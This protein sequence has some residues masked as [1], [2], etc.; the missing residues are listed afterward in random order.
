MRSALAAVLAVLVLPLLAVPAAADPGDIDPGGGFLGRVGID[1]LSGT[2]AP[3]PD[4]R[5]LVPLRCGDG[6]GTVGRIDATGRREQTFAAGGTVPFTIDRLLD[7]PGG[8]LALGFGHVARFTAEGQLDPTFGTAGVVT[9]PG[10]PVGA[11]TSEPPSPRSASAA[12]DGSIYVGSAVVVANVCVRTAALVTKLGPAGAIDT[13]FGNGGSVQVHVSDLDAATSVV[14]Q[15]DGVL[16]GVA[17]RRPVVGS[18]CSYAES[19]DGGLVIRYKADGTPLTTFGFNGVLGFD[20]IHDGRSYLYGTGLAYDAGQDRLVMAHG[21]QVRIATLDGA[22][23]RTVDPGP[24]N[25]TWVGID[26]ASRIVVGGDRL[27]RLDPDGD[28]DLSWGSCGITDLVGGASFALEADGDVQAQV[29]TVIYRLGASAGA[30]APAASQTASAWLVAADGSVHTWGD[31]L[32]CGPAGRLPNRAAPVGIAAAPSGNGY[33]VVSS[34]GDVTGFGHAHDLGDMAGRRLNQPVVGMAPTPTGQGYWLVARDGGIFSFGDARFFGS[35]GNIRLNE[36]IVGMTASPGGQGYW[37]V[38][39]DGGI[40][41][42]GD[43]RFYGSTGAHPPSTPIVGM[44]A[45]PGGNGYFLAAAG[46]GVYKFGPGATQVGGANQPIGR[47]V[48]IAALATGGHVVF[49]ADGRVA[50]YG[51]GPPVQVVSGR[52]IVA[53]FG[54]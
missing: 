27:A 47:L 12:P 52:T 36:P 30:A 28:K 22:I 35:T 11:G 49:G 25:A 20:T 10:V 9:L 48:G 50:S 8:V 3:Q 6:C 17:T 14:A 37:F 32:W 18:H 13:T 4:G 5:T 26:P 39:S 51:G 41:A 46:G 23:V 19:D 33:W 2:P 40:F 24:M 29:G 43:A 34:D 21:H 16:V 7:V 15:P 44:A 1:E 45:A 53:G 54:R 38:A 42:Y 31:A